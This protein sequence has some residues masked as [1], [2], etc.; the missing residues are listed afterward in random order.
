M[1]LACDRQ[2]RRLWCRPLPRPC[3][4]SASRLFVAVLLLS[5]IVFDRCIVC[6]SSVE[7]FVCQLQCSLSLRS[8]R[9]SY[10]PCR[11]YTRA[12][13]RACNGR[14][15]P[16]VMPDVTC[17]INDRSTSRIHETRQKQTQKTSRM[18]K[19][20]CTLWG[21]NPRS[22][23]LVPETSALTTRPRVLFTYQLG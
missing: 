5:S 14:A 19:E 9:L 6:T 2:R 15:A 1:N 17:N 23:E 13:N 3:V 11:L 16:S 18:R 20:K 12:A 10:A 7:L 22:Y 21:S 4:V 8:A